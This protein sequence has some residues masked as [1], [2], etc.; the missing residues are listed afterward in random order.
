MALFG[1]SSRTANIVFDDYIVRMI[2]NNGKDLNSVRNIKE[3]YLPEKII[4]NGRIVDEP[5][6][7][8][9]MKNAVQEWGIKNRQ[10]RFFVPQSLVILREVEV[11]DDVKQEDIKGYIH[12]EVGNTIHFPFKNPIFDVLPKQEGSNKVTVV[13]APENELL[14]YTEILT[15]V[16]LKPSVA[17]IQP[18]GIYRY[19]LHNTAKSDLNLAYMFVEYN[20]TS[21]NISIFRG[22]KLEFL[23]H[24]PL[25]ALKEFWEIDVETSSFT[26]IGDDI[27]YQGEI[28]D[29]LNEM[30]RIMNFYRFS[31]HQGEHQ[32]NELIIV[33]DSP[34]LAKITKLIAERFT[35][36][37]TTLEV[38]E[39]V[40]GEVLST[41][42][43]PALG[44]ALRG[45][46]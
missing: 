1:S 10:A 46:K 6:F 14:K 8:N 23:R 21:V 40:D 11:P 45:G 37:V 9:F 5:A 30:E 16:S 19:F 12:L 44:L 43:I 41:A 32:V 17:E 3:K 42:F 13:A 18:F 28:D 22:N 25:I 7:F 27:R 2:E 15:D 4:E 34:H 29:Q 38:Q 35:Q 24:Q 33:G 20:L 31:L 39:Q 26:F 36:Q